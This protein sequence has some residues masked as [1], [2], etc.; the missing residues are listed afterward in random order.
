MK[1]RVL[2]TFL[3]PLLFA[4]SSVSLAFAVGE[5]SRHELCSQRYAAGQIDAQINFCCQQDIYDHD[6][7]DKAYKKSIDKTAAPTHYTFSI[8]GLYIKT[9]EGLDA[10]KKQY[11]FYFSCLDAGQ[12]TNDCKSA[13]DFEMAVLLNRNNCLS[14]G[15]SCNVEEDVYSAAVYCGTP[16]CPEEAA[17]R[18]Y[19]AWQASKQSN[20][21]Q[22][23]DDAAAKA[24]QE[25]ADQQAAD[26]ATANEAEDQQAATEAAETTDSST[27]AEQDKTTDA[28]EPAAKPAPVIGHFAAVA[29]SVQVLQ[30]DGTW[31]SVD[32]G[33]ALHLNDRIRANDK[34]RL[35]ILFADE[36]IT[37]LGPNTDMVIGTD[38]YNPDVAGGDMSIEL[39]T[40]TFR[41]VTGKITA[42]EPNKIK[43][44]A[45]DVVGIGIRGSDLIVEYDPTKGSVITYLHEGAFTITPYATNKTQNYS[46][47]QIVMLDSKSVQKVT[48]LSQEEWNSQVNSLQ[49]VA[50]NKS[51]SNG[52]SSS[53]SIVIGLIVII[54]GIIA[55]AGGIYYFFKIRKK[56]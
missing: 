32:S 56:K 41:Y 49:I 3:V 44:N 29:G 17:Q 19:D 25:Q 11:D 38:V 40:G 26:D 37:T 53:I 8:D 6:A 4:L 12:S 7:C 27:V 16:N 43:V 22:A 9:Q 18:D 47:G 14:E 1:K 31:K 36:T 52:N 35:Q 24:A 54:G 50:E 48:P 51:E 45:G 42:K 21:Q 39:N 2:I 55:V 46:A 10:A 28:Q 30:P 20:A 5:P 23:A 15:R 33:S 13:K 34:G